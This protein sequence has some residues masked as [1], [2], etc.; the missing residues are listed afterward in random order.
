MFRLHLCSLPLFNNNYTKTNGTLKCV[1]M[2]NVLLSTKLGEFLFQRPKIL[3]RYGS[4]V[5]EFYY[6]FN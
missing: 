6:N 3:Q 2:R 5:E 1:G 4:S